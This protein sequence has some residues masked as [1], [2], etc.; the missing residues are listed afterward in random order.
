M[1]TTSISIIPR[2]SVVKEKEKLI[3][4][5]TAWLISRDIIKAIPV[6]SSFGERGERY[7]IADGARAVIND[8]QHMTF[9]LKSSELEITRQRTIFTSMEGGLEL[10][11]CP[12]CKQNLAQEDWNFFDRWASGSTND[13][14][15]PFCR[16]S[17]EVHEYTF[18][19]TWGFSDL[20]FSFWNWTEC[21]PE[22]I[23]E[24]TQ[25]LAMEVDVVYARI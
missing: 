15:C 8:P 18:S 25:R 19:P 5:I 21:T 20:G 3:K 17:H 10:L 2:V 23:Q 9:Y 16:G 4:D 12:R 14:V 6:C 7:P 1:G 24:F 13:I 22:F 11:L